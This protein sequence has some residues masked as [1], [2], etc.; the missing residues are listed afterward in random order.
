MNPHVTLASFITLALIITG[1]TIS[2]ILWLFA[3]NDLSNKILSAAILSVTAS[4]AFGFINQTYL[5]L[6]LPHF[7]RLGLVAA[8]ISYVLTFF[9][10]R[11]AV[12]KT[13]IRP[14]DFLHAI[15][16][17]VYIIDFLPFFM[18][19]GHEKLE[20]IQLDLYGYYEVK[21][22]DEGWLTPPGFY[23]YIRHL[24]MTVYWMLQ[25]RILFLFYTRATRTITWSRL[26]TRLWLTYFVGSQALG[27]MPQFITPQDVSAQWILAIVSAG[28]PILITTIWLFLQPGILYGLN[29]PKNAI[30][31]R[32]KKNRI[33]T[34]PPTPY[35]QEFSE[36][37]HNFMSK[38][39]KFLQHRYT[40]NDLARELNVPPHQLS[41]FLNQQL[42][43]SFSDFL[44]KFRIEYCMERIKNG[45]AR[46]L[47]LE[48]L[49]S[50]CGF[51][52]RNSFTAA[53]KRLAGVTPSDFMRDLA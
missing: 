8:L 4:L 28:L 18:L 31:L 24:M 14:R 47:T 7:Y 33:P 49:A 17:L 13:S 41:A 53:F 46:R 35:E 40:I 30:A 34:K 43:T 1:L 20:L 48:A 19:S 26:K 51:N 11:S 52:N 21:D 36:R 39:R 37:L 12:L 5:I 16:V 25:V 23:F 32:A 15:P 2:L 10:V 27:F 50:E 22:F 42:N 38:S 3:K 6:K 44:N 29:I 9:Y 45:D